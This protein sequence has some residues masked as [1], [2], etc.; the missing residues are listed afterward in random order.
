ML[1]NAFHAVMYWAPVLIICAAIGAR[2]AAPYPYGSKDTAQILTESLTVV[3]RELQD[4]GTVY[5]TVDGS[6]PDTDLLTTLN[7]RPGAP[8]F[9]PGKARSLEL[10]HCRVTPR[11]GLVVGSCMQD[12]FLSAELLSMPLWH[13]A[14]VRVKTA[15]CT[16]ELTLAQ[17]NTDWHVLSQ[18]TSCR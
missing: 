12:N 6:D 14:L 7:S 9:T 13:V 3:A 15:G 8:A 18:R 1:R 17:G 16:A 5:V 4:K 2:A 11:G 10:E